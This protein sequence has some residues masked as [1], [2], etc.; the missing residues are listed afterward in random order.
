MP[1]KNIKQKREYNRL[2][3]LKIKNKTIEAVGAPIEV[4]IEAVGAPIEVPNDNNFNDYIDY[5]LVNNLLHKQQYNPFTIW[6]LNIQEV[7]MVYKVKTDYILFKKRYKFMMTEFLKKA[8]YPKLIYELDQCK[9]LLKSTDGLTT[10]FYITV[11][12]KSYVNN[13]EIANNMLL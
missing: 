4:P 12:L 3:K 10:P 5:N 6:F 2:Y 1:Y 7:N 9:Y 11:P 13:I 8:L